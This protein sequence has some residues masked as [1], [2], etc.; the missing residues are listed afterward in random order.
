MEVAD[1]LQGREP[2]TLNNLRLSH[3]TSGG[4]EEPFVKTRPVGRPKPA[5]RRTPKRKYATDS[6]P[7]QPTR[8]PCPVAPHRPDQPGRRAG[9]RRMLRRLDLRRP[10]F[11]GGRLARVRRRRPSRHQS[12][13]ESAAGLCCPARASASSGELRQPEGHLVLDHTTLSPLPGGEVRQLIEVSDDGGHYVEAGVRRRFF[14]RRRDTSVREGPQLP[15][16]MLA[17]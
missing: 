13:L 9:C 15:G 5:R 8:G 1:P 14:G 12:H 16:R 17:R 7:R 2:S 10:R 11:P 3:G 6:R 4:A